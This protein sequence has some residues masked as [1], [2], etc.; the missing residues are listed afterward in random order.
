MIKRHGM[1]SAIVDAF[2]NELNAIAKG[3]MPELETL[4]H[5]VMDAEE[6]DLS[7]LS[8]EEVDYVKTTRM[9]MGLNLYSDSW[10][11]L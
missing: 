6:I 4:I 9:L 11:D 3:K 1:Y 2:D 8:K 7:K 5:K 10:L